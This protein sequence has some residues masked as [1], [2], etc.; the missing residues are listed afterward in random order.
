MW[1]FLFLILITTFVTAQEFKGKVVFIT[2]ASTGIGY[3]TALEFA[4]SGAHVAFCSRNR[5]PDWYT[6]EEAETKINNDHLVRQAGGSA[7][8]VR[9]D[10]TNRVQVRN[11]IQRV[12]ARYRKLDILINNAGIGGYLGPIHTIPEYIIKGEHD[13]METNFYGTFHCMQEVIAYWVRTHQETYKNGQPPEDLISGIIVNLSSYSGIRSAAMGTMYSASKAAVVGLTKSAAL[14]FANPPTQV[15]PRLRIN[16]IAAG[17]ID[18][19]FTRNQ[20]KFMKN[21]TQ[22]WEGRLIRENDPEW[23]EMKKTVIE[24]ALVGQ[25]LGTPTQVA[26]II[27]HLCSEKSR[28]ITGT[29]VSADF[30]MNAR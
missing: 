15:M 14:E 13:P 29:V 11:A 24:P 22:T 19:A 30:G 23:L 8:F 26:N 10:V 9:A 17:L 25:R 5:R 7:Y 27:M 1:K 16:A 4:R 2:G 3:A 18:T 20:I 6:G 12:L 28:Y 21:G